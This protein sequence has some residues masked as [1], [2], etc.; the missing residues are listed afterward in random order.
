MDRRPRAQ[1]HVLPW[2]S[3]L[4]CSRALAFGRA[5]CGMVGAQRDGTSQFSLS[6]GKKSA[7]FLLDGN[8][9]LAAPVLNPIAS[10]PQ[11]LRQSA[12]PGEET[13]G[14]EEHVV[15]AQLRGLGAVVT[16]VPR[17]ERH[18][19]GPDRRGPAAPVSGASGPRRPRE[20]LGRGSG[21][22]VVRLGA[23]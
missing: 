21:F 13:S 1:C 20:G 18:P 5:P 22:G 19:L 2:G 12:G 11:V 4:K 17:P 3:I 16:G 15:P 7:G 14:Q 8:V 10:L 6:L 23:G 9:I